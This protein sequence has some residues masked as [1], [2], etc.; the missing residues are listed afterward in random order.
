MSESLTMAGKTREQRL[1]WCL[2]FNY[3]STVTLLS[4]TD[5]GLSLSVVVNRRRLASKLG[6]L[7][8]ASVCHRQCESERFP[9]QTC[10]KLF[11]TRGNMIQ[12]LKY[13][14]SMKSSAALFSY[15]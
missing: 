4:G 14:I 6:Y 12:Q 5:D 1:S 13:V 11:P 8:D 15:Y 3:Y 7:Q 10:F 2:R 9:Q